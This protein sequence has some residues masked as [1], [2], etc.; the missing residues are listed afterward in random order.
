K[1]VFTWS[2]DP[3]VISV[4]P[5][6][7]FGKYEALARHPGAATRSAA[8]S[9]RSR[10]RFIVWLLSGRLVRC[11]DRVGGVPRNRHMSPGT[12]AERARGKPTSYLSAGGFPVLP[13][14]IPAA[15]R[16]TSSKA[17]RADS[18]RRRAHALLR[19]TYVQRRA[20][21]P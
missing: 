17:M 16:H 12:F 6:W 3:V 9:S 7:S 5:P 8:A 20:V 14:G 2:I 18:P 4:Y 21:T 11:S 10:I 13:R 19:V 1:R 15:S